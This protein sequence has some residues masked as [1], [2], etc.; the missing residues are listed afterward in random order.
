MKVHFLGTKANIKTTKPYH[1]LHSGILID[2]RL[3][4]DLGERDFLEYY[5]DYLFF[6]HFHPD[7]AYFV[8]EKENFEAPVPCYGPEAHERVGE[9]EIMNE[10]VE[11]AGYREKQCI[12]LINEAF[13]Y[14]FLSFS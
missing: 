8:E 14:F 3:M 5:F 1:A 11:V 6:T 13:L 7:H 9:M 10:P 2:D 12:G 4:F